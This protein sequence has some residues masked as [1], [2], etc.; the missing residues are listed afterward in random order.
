MTPFETWI[1]FY[2][3]VRK[4]IVRIVRIWP[5]TFLPAVV[6]SVLYFLIFGTVLGSRI[7]EFQGVD[8]VAF[9]VPGLIML[10][11]V[12]NAFSNVAFV[13]FS[14]KFFA[15]NIDEL[16]VSPT[17]PSII[18]AGFVASGIVRGIGVG[19]L[20][21]LTSIP[22]AGLS[23]H[24]LPVV[25]VFLILTSLALSLGGL[26]NGIHAQSIDGINIIPTFV[27]TPLV[28][29]GGIFYSVE[30]LPSFWQ[31]VT[32]ANPIFYIV[33]GFRYGF[34]GIS[35]TPLLLSG[36]VLLAVSAVLGL[37]AWYEI[38]SGLRLKQ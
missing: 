13:M 11:V 27:L 2:T 10:A 31:G 36:G 35:D 30:A 37:I 1:S 17:P 4:D 15:R 33:D 16:L 5:Q 12:T 19:V 22:F 34:L 14:S 20:V 28:Y 3:I 18:V 9:V 8:F 7:G 38:R 6:T 24:S 26:I 32:H 25:L 23:I 21:F 29:L